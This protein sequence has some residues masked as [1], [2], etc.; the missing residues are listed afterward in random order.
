MIEITKEE[1]EQNVEQNMQL[2]FAWTKMPFYT[3]KDA[4]GVAY[5]ASM[6]PIQDIE[7]FKY[8]TDKYY[9]TNPIVGL[10]PWTANVK[11]GGMAFEFQL[12]Q[13][14]NYADPNNRRYNL[15]ITEELL[16]ISRFVIIVH[17]LLLIFRVT[18]SIRRRV[19]Q[20]L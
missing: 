2:T 13:D 1:Y 14:W 10:G 7:Y 15:K 6:S 12:N 8:T 20:V 3:F 4:V 18:I 5:H 19:I 9:S 16:L 11:T 17:S